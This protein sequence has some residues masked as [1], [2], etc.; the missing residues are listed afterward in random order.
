MIGATVVLVLTNCTSLTP[1]IK[2]GIVALRSS[3]LVITGP[4][5]DVI[6]VIVVGVG[7]FVPGTNGDSKILT[8]EPTLNEPNPL[9]NA[10]F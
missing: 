9:I 8:L 3:K 10:P 2:L 5:G 1:L 6:S 7:A 4:V